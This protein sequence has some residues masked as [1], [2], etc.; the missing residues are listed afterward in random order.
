MEAAISLKWICYSSN[1][2]N[3]KKIYI[4]HNVS[5][6]GFL[7]LLKPN[8]FLT[9]L[10]QHV[11]NVTEES[12][13]NP[14][15]DLLCVTSFIESIALNAITFVDPKRTMSVAKVSSPENRELSFEVVQFLARD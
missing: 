12:K 15:L 10:S 8:C 5:L 11:C 3:F 4:L 2:F 7:V 1:A 14:S 13:G 6:F 9:E